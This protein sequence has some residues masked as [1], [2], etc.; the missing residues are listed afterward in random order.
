MRPL[1]VLTPQAMQFLT[2]FLFYSLFKT[3]EK[4]TLSR[5]QLSWTNQRHHRAA[6]SVWLRKHLILINSTFKRV[7][8][9][10]SCPHIWKFNNAGSH[11]GSNVVELEQQGG[12]GGGRGAAQTA[13]VERASAWQQQPRHHKSTPHTHTHAHAHARACLLGLVI[14]AIVTSNG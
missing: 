8:D 7:R 2:F 11:W 3:H 10:E 1:A 9:S 14:V 4:K 6:L 13:D 5:A 12:R